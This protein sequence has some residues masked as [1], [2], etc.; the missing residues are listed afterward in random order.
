MS[1]VASATRVQRVRHEIKLRALRVLRVAELSP[2]VRS[3]TFGGE[4]LADFV[5]AS[6]DDHVKFIIAG[7]DGEPLRRDYTPRRFDTAARQLTLEFALHGSGPAAS[8]AAQAAAGQE[9]TVAGPRGS[10]I[11]EAGLDWHLLVGDLSALPAIARR[12]EELP[13][14]TQATVILQVA[15]ERDRRK[16]ET[17]AG[18]TL[19]WVASADELVA[20]VRALA[21]PD[22]EGFAW[23]AGEAGASAAVRAIL[24]GEKGLPAH[25]VRAAAYWKQGAAAHHENLE[26]LT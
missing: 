18:I 15:D 4:A 13:A 24:V 11:V 6:F 23:C 17:A 3:V 26:S 2:H 1:I 19:R 5:S 7:P 12:L 20:A 14:Q 8:W 22:G 21:L 25:A 9:V 10:F 16:L